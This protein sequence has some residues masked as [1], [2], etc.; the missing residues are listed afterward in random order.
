[1][2]L[3][4]EASDRIQEF[5]E[6]NPASKGMGTTATTVIAHAG[7]AWWAHVGDSR[8]YLT[9]NGITGQ[10]TCDQS[11]AWFLVEEGEI[12][13]EEASSHQS[14]NILDQALGQGSGPCDPETGS[15]QIRE[16]DQLTLMT[17]GIHGELPP[18]AISSILADRA[19]IE[20]KVKRLSGEA[21]DAGGSDN[22]TIVM[23]QI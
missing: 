18:K 11:M 9:R 16:G 4:K 10:I 17:D 1:M 20:A 3:M 12:T 23:A 14:R 7:R 5:A 8:L 15:L 22:L 2:A 13:E 6:K 19:G 21:L